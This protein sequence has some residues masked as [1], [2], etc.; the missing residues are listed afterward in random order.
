M[1]VKQKKTKQ[2]FKFVSTAIKMTSLLATETAELI[3]TVST[4]KNQLHFIIKLVFEIVLS[5]LHLRKNLKILIIC[6]LN[7][8]KG[9]NKYLVFL[10]GI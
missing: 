3:L 2:L 6:H 10:C 5:T 8:P 1:R 4:D 7:V 9:F